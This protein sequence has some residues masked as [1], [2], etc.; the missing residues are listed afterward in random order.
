AAADS[1]VGRH[2]GDLAA[3]APT[4]EELLT[5]A[6]WARTQDTSEEFR[7]MLVALLRHMGADDQA[8][9]LLDDY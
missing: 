1:G 3:L 8:E 4:G 6:R 5:A 2:T 7:T 9:R